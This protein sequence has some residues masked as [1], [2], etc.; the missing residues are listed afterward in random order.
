MT[1]DRLTESTP[2]PPAPVVASGSARR[3]ISWRSIL[4]SFLLVLL[5]IGWWTLVYTFLVAGWWLINGYTFQ[6]GPGNP[7]QWNGLVDW[8]IMILALLSVWPAQRWLRPRVA[9]FV[10]DAGDDPYTAISR[11]SARLDTELTAEAL[12]LAIAHSLTE[13]LNLPW[14]ELETSEGSTAESGPRPDEPLITLP[15]QY[16]GRALGELRFA[17]RVVAG[18]PLP[19]DG[20]LLGDLA[21]Q[22]SLALYNNEL[23]AELQESR[24]RIITAGEEGRRTLRR[25][26]HD[27]LG[28]AL[29]TMTMQAETARELLRDDP[30]AADRALAGLI[31]QAQATVSEVRRIVHGLRPPALDELGLY[32]ALE[33]LA[34]GFASPGLRVELRLPK[35]RQ[36]LSAAVE[37]AV[38]RIA[39]E[40]LTNVSRHARAQTATL[41]LWFEGDG[42]RLEVTDDGVGLPPALEPGLGLASMRDRAEGI[43]GTLTIL[44]NR[45]RGTCIT[46]RFPLE[47]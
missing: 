23:T 42:L 31:D 43:G 13:I 29:A 27:G 19:V 20:Q 25:D 9:L 22:I 3:I 17:P 11:V 7:Y 34:D 44:P 28:P 4:S 1:E 40:A 12:P 37:V 18:L 39:Q 8:I 15:L 36:T 24:R 2:D 6:E 35:E 14:V 38:Y 16:N 46:A 33:V 41:A 32:G 21:R 47:T 5:L 26:L 10:E 45:P 30:A